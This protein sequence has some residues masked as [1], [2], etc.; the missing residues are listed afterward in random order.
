MR[1]LDTETG[2]SA[3]VP[4][5]WL[6]NDSHDNWYM[7]TEGNYSCDCNRA[8]F[9]ARFRDVPE[10]EDPPCGEGRFKLLD[11]PWEDVDLAIRTLRG[12]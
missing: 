2:L 6:P 12:T 10:P 9:H 1:I 5:D 11:A 3:E 8:L 7:W 4:E